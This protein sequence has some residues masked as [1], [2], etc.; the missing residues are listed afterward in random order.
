MPFKAGK[1]LDVIVME[2]KIG[3]K[4]NKCGDTGCDCK[5]TPGA[6]A[7]LAVLFL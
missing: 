3:Y 4:I 1:I 6:R 5:A 2:A 7:S